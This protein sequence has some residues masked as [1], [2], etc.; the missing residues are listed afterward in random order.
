VATEDIH[1]VIL[2]WHGVLQPGRAAVVRAVLASAH[3]PVLL[4]PR[5]QAE[6]T[7]AEAEAEAAA[8]PPR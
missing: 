7:L 3:V 4:V 8:T 5:A 6:R 1:A 2:G